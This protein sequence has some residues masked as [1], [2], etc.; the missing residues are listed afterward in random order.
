M[1]CVWSVNR[2]ILNE[3]SL[4]FYMSFRIDYSEGKARCG[5]FSTEHGV[6]HTPAFMPVGTQ[7]TVKAIEQRELVEIG[8]EIVLSNTYH[9]YLRP[10]ME[11]LRA[12]GGLHRFMGW[13][14]PILTDSG[15][16]QIFSLSELR[17][18][19]DDGV[20]FRSHLDG[21]LHFF[22]PESVVDIQRTI[23]SDI[24]MV[25]D[26]CAPYPCTVE[27]A[28]KSNNLTV[29]WAERC[30]KQFMVT[31]PCYGHEQSLFAVVQ[32]S[33]Y[34][35]VREKSV[36]ALTNI[37][38]DGYAIGGLAV[39]EPTEQ[40]YE[41]VSLCTD[42]LPEKK[43]RYVMGV[44][45]PQNIIECIERGADMFDCVLPTRNGRNSML[46]TRSGTLNITNAQYKNDFTPVD[47]ECYCYTCQKFT[48]AYMRH[49]F[50][51]K[52]I[53]GLQLATIH[54]LH[55]YQWMM[56]E[57]RKA[58]MQHRFVIWKEEMF[59]LLKQDVLIQQQ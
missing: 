37:G 8:T 17:T 26:E 32:G 30:F 45:T 57:A 15:G 59:R 12:A 7:G 18:L 50:Q 51:S 14:K 13:E 48:R 33:V 20:R 27:Y 52:E 46:F 42:M 29:R 5:V 35:E 21:S 36:I 2:C 58:I 49:L 43:P 38:F 10:G 9:L 28:I 56:Q 44:G 11:I 34:P 54:N 16:Y 3:K 6:F 25:L 53:L 55:F 24:M 40:L 4:F 39:G 41:I 22:T 31:N 47:E 1:F 23:G 19:T